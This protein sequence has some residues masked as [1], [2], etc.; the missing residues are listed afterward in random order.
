M[1]LNENGD[2]DSIWSRRV[3]SISKRTVNKEGC[4]ESC[5]QVPEA[6]GCEYGTDSTGK[7]YC[8]AFSYSVSAEID[9][10]AKFYKPPMFCWTI[11]RSN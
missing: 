8:N 7:R 2:R 4:L 9:E 5:M 6:L 3:R 1:C 11:N 10:Y